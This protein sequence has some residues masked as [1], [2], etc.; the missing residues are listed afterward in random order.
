MNKDKQKNWHDIKKQSE[1]EEERFNEQLVDEEDEQPTDAI[2][3]EQAALEHPSYSELEKKLTLA[4]QL[5]HENREKAMRAMAELDNVRRSTERE[6]AKAYSYSTGKLINALLPVMDSLEQAL[7][8]VLKDGETSM[9]EGL[10]LTMD[11]FIDVL[12]KQGVVQLNPEGA[13]FNPQEHEAMSIQEVPGLADNTIVTVLQK[14][15]QL[16]ER[17]IRPARVI[18]AKARKA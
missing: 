6:I 1:L 2:P 11:L 14:G 16:N 4:E 13:L 8:V 15:Y 10:Q 7:Q 3:K 17:L 12:E 18:V 9:V 5:A